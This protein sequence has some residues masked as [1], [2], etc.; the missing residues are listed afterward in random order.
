VR[1]IEVMQNTEEQVREAL[2]SALDLTEELQPPEDLRVAAFVKA[3]DLL[4]AKQVVLD[5]AGGAVLPGSILGH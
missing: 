1:R 3:A 4:S 2:R 5:A